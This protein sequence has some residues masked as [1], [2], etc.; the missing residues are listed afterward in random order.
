MTDK[1]QLPLVYSC[2]GCSSSAQMSNHFAIALDRRG[3][4]EMSCIAG[5][6]AGVP[7]LV[8]VAKKAAE[9]GRPI[10]A[11]DGCALTCVKHA[12]A[13]H[14]IEATVAHEL[15][16]YEVKKI[17]G[18]DFDPDEANDVLERVVLPSIPSTQPAPQA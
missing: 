3:L 9:T 14:G 11:I 16:D 17:K 15:Q 13:C 2:S 5:V 1:S 12:L 6:G 7:S 10:I 18:Q 4:A 8:K